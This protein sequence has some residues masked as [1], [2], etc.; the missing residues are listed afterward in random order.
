[1]VG[2]PIHSQA[3]E[4]LDMV[5]LYFEAVKVGD[6]DTIQSY[7]GGKILKK[8]KILLEENTEYP[9]FLRDRF[10]AAE[11]L[12]RPSSNEQSEAN[13]ELV[14]VQIIF[15]DGS[16]FSTELVVEQDTSGEWKIIEQL[17]N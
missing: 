7:L 5:R 9:N 10:G 15:S 16:S 4:P 6:V 3:A 17:N 8:R 12:I 2:V 13:G 11:F 1:M 14:N